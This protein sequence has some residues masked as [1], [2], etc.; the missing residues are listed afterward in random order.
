MDTKSYKISIPRQ[1]Y[2]GLVGFLQR[3]GKLYGMPGAVVFRGTLRSQSKKGCGA[4]VHQSVGV[5]DAAAISKRYNTA[6][7]GLGRALVKKTEAILDLR[8]LTEEEMDAMHFVAQVAMLKPQ[9]ERVMVRV[10][11]TIT[12]FLALPAMMRLALAAAD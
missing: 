2:D 4:V 7:C 9:Q 10:T 12:A 6:T 3:W 11:A 8:D 5:G 1:T